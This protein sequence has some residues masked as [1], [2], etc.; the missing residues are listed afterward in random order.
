MSPQT[1]IDLL[2][3]IQQTTLTISSPNGFDMLHI[4]GIFPGVFAASN[5]VQ[6]GVD[7]LLHQ[8][9]TADTAILVIAVKGV[10][11]LEGSHNF[12][13]TGGEPSAGGEFFAFNESSGHA[14]QLAG[15]IGSAGTFGT[16]AGSLGAAFGVYSQTGP[17][18]PGLITNDYSI[19]IASP[20]IQGPMTNHWGLFIDDQTIGGSNNPN[21]WAIWVVGGN[22]N[23]G[24]DKVTVAKLK[25]TGLS[26]FANN[27]AA[28]TGGL[29][30]GEFYRTGA[31]PDAVCV[32]H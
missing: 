8:V 22:I 29:G 16:G 9:P 17:Q 26:V 25:V 23:L 28:I 15:V 7:V 11:Q 10:V 14:A 2:T 24:P 32:V 18:G 31:D 13:S 19:F 27:A 3:Q 4:E 5:I 6:S 21:P 12:P 30:V 20:N 1:K